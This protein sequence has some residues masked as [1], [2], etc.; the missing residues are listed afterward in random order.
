MTYQSRRSEKNPG[1]DSAPH[2]S[3]PRTRI[4]S[5]NLLPKQGFVDS[6]M[7]ITVYHSL[8]RWHWCFKNHFFISSLDTP[9]IVLIWL[10]K[11]WPLLNCA[12]QREHLNL[13]M[14]L[15][16]NS[17][18]FRSAWTLNFFG[19]KWH[20]NDLLLSSCALNL[21]P[22]SWWF[23]LYDLPQ[24]SHEYDLIPSCT[25]DVCSFKRASKKEKNGVEM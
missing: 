5:A 11:W 22:L 1:L 21:W 7:K 14:F 16:I 20:K 15:W 10:S 4:S 6:Q 9:W 13:L 12:S 3:G 23:N 25:V 2:S 18:F 17:C 19:Q 8:M 24:I